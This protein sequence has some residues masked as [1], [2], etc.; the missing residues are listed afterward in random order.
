MRQPPRPS[1]ALPIML[2]VLLL[3]MTASFSMNS[4]QRE[5]LPAE[6]VARD[7]HSNSNL[8]AAGFQSGSIYSNTTLTASISY[9]CVNMQDNRMKCWGHSHQGQTGTGSWGDLSTPTYVL[10]GSAGGQSTATSHGSFGQHTIAVMV[11]GSMQA[12]GQ[13]GWGQLGHGHWGGSHPTP[14]IVMMP[15]GRT[16][17]HAETGWLTSCAVMD[18][19]SLWCWG[20]NDPYGQVGNNA[21]DGSTAE[22]V[23]PV[24]I[25]LP[26]NRGVIALSMGYNF[27]CILLD[28][29]DGMCWGANTH[30]QLG[31]G[32]SLTGGETYQNSV[33]EP[34]TI[35]PQN[36]DLVAI[37]AGQAHV[38]GILDNGSVVC[39]GSGIQGQLGDGT[40]SHNSTTPRYV[41]L[42]A[43]KTATSITAGLRHNCAILDDHSS[44]C[45]GN[46]SNGQ[47]GDGTYIDFSFGSMNNS[48]AN[49]NTPVAVS[50]PAGVEFATISA[51]N[52]HTC[53]IATNG[54]VWCWGRHTNGQLGLGWIGGSY[55]D[56][57]VPA[58][59]NLSGESAGPWAHAALGERD[60]DGDGILSIFDQTPYGPPICPVGQFLD[61]ALEVCI[62]ASPGHYVPA[63]GMDEQIPCSNGTY[64]PY[65]GQSSCLETSPGHY[66]SGIAS[67][68]QTECPEGTYQPNSNQ[69]S[70]IDTNPGNFSP[71]GASSQTPCPVGTYGPNSAMAA[72]LAAEPGHYVWQPMQ[73]EQIPCPPGKFQPNIGATSCL[74]AHEGHYIPGEG[75]TGQEAGFV[76]FAGIECEPGTYSDRR[77]LD[78]CKEADPGNYVP[79]SSATGQLACSAGFN[80]PST[81]STECLSNEPGYYTYEDGTANP[82][83]CPGGNYQPDSESTGCIETDPGHY[84]PGPAATHQTV[85][86]AGTYAPQGGMDQCTPA[87][88]GN[89]VSAAGATSSEECAAGTHQPSVGASSCVENEAG[90]YTDLGGA[91]V[92]TPCSPGMYQDSTGQTSCIEADYGYHAPESA[93]TN[94]EPCPAGTYQSSTGQSGCNP[95]EKGRYVDES[96]STESTPCDS[97]TYQPDEGQAGCIEADPGHYVSSDESEAQTPCDRGTY[98]GESAQTK[99]IDS[100][101]GYFV[102][103]SA[104]TS[105]TACEPGS[106]QPI[107]GMMG[108]RAAEIDHYVAESG[109][110]SQRKC[111]DGE[112]QPEAGQTS[113]IEEE[114]SM[115]LI[116]AAGA[117]VV[118]LVLFFMQSQ[119][120]PKSPPPRR[121]KRR[122][123]KGKRRKRR[124]PRPTAIEPSREEE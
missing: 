23:L 115:M 99:C 63:S 64:Q 62:E 70:C 119:K 32:V 116:A 97:G 87:S 108:C 57:D 55:V 102:A 78:A 61:V 30:G 31:N 122:P 42:P 80:Q 113:C 86:D 12:W 17:I 34:I 117:A 100:D 76:L 13:D 101:P 89:F 25:P 26:A 69:T 81:G 9:T 123:P 91:E 15:S 58:W 67:T 59:V 92:Q 6:E 39:W 1:N 111:P 107:S 11:D 46:N 52:F 106:Y 28:N 8:S 118:A 35:I 10:L 3:G 4:E 54:S 83:A 44:W 74:S 88:P 71:A 14:S 68:S 47:I 37:A 36:R 121:G 65:S 95:A 105:Q 104:G 40:H 77:G 103:V 18:D 53:A 5:G 41:S 20:R 66:S 19:Q 73:T 94:Q 16:A 27:A 38:C 110:S 48:S 114:G 93:A 21:S 72:C 24:N 2:V 22:V 84:A 60:H 112:Y 56:S 90:H 124:K 79:G 43:G 33:P 85:C 120:K 45:W 50:M 29:H 75:S 109:A 7:T 82:L 98:Q 49:P 96:A 51:G